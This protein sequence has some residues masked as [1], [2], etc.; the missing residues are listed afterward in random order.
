MLWV[1]TFTDHFTPDVGRAAVRLLESAGYRVQLT[2]KRV[3]CGLTWVSTGQLGLAQRVLKRT[4]G[5]LRAE[6]RAGTP[7]VG[8]VQQQGSAQSC[9]GA[10]FP[11]LVLFAWLC[12]KG[13]G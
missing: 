10:L 2:D 7:V 8:L 6:I 5:I 4:L 3:C 1:D 12:D 11:L 13:A 9:G